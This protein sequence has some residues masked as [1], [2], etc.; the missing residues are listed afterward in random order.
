MT[1][2]GVPRSRELIIYVTIRVRQRIWSKQHVGR[3]V[4]QNVRRHPSTVGILSLKVYLGED[5]FFCCIVK[6]TYQKCS[7]TF[8]LL[9]NSNSR[10]KTGPFF[11]FMWQTSQLS[12]SFRTQTLLMNFY[13]LRLL[14]KNKG[15]THLDLKAAVRT[16]Y[17]LF[18]T[19]DNLQKSGNDS[20][21]MA[22]KNVTGGGT[23]TKTFQRLLCSPLWVGDSK[24]QSL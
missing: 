8:P 15:L 21:M 14:F 2:H 3:C 18:A 1:I 11:S 20:R 17:S 16:K 9:L 12:G 19:K 10:R 5:I 24:Q 7:F 6:L 22:T 13:S 4:G 23:Q